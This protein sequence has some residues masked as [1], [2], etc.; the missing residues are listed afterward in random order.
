MDNNVAEES[1]RPE[2]AGKNTAILPTFPQACRASKIK[3]YAYFEDLLRRY[4]S[5]T[6]KNLEELLPANWINSRN[7]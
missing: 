2:A 7:K 5:H 3:A 1:L 6:Y 4:Q